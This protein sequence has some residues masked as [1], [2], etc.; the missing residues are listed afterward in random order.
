MFPYDGSIPQVYASVPYFKPQLIAEEYEYVSTAFQNKPSYGIDWPPKAYEQ[1]FDEEGNPILDENGNPVFSEK[2]QDVWPP[3]VS[4]Y[5]WEP[6][7]GTI[8]NGSIPRWL[9]PPSFTVSW[10]AKEN[11]GTE[12]EKTVA[13][14]NYSWTWDDDYRFGMVLRKEEYPFI[15][16]EYTQVGDTLIGSTKIYCSGRP[17][18][19]EDTEGWPEAFRYGATSY[20]IH[21]A[22]DGDDAWIGDAPSLTGQDEPTWFLKPVLNESG[23]EVANPRYV[24]E[25]NRFNI[26]Q[27]LMAYI[28]LS[29]PPSSTGGVGD[30]K[31]WEIHYKHWHKYKVNYAPQDLNANNFYSN[32]TNPDIEIES[33]AY[34]P[35]GFKYVERYKSTYEYGIYS[36]GPYKKLNNVQLSQEFHF[37]TRNFSFTASGVGVE[38]ATP[39]YNYEW[40]VSSRTENGYYAFDRGMHPESPEWNG[41]KGIGATLDWVYKDWNV[42]QNAETLEE[43]YYYPYFTEVGIPSFQSF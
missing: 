2:E 27:D 37:T 40:K 33:E 42:V 21:N 10:E 9:Y 31:G 11:I 28:G 43:S 30:T 24:G 18:D 5:Y 16:T 32:P 6:F 29:Q 34:D 39:V 1:E 41:P 35:T 4:P 20:P 23:E 22:T 17:T 14:Y 26:A 25:E 8:N 19:T 12:Y 3:P 7:F 36:P 15:W 13:V 38:G